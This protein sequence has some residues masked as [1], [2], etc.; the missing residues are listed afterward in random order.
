[1]LAV[2]YRHLIESG[3]FEFD[4]SGTYASKPI[5][6]QGEPQ[7]PA[8]PFVA[9]SKVE[10]RFGLPTTGRAA[11]IWCH[12]R[13]YLPRRYGFSENVLINRLFGERFWERDFLTRHAYGFQGLREE[14][15][16]DLIPIALPQVRGVVSDPWR[17]GLCL[18]QHRHRCPGVDPDRRPR[19]PPGVGHTRLAAALYSPIGDRYD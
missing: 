6:Q 18:L 14:D 1:M 15:D 13:R 5:E 12:L 8:I 17:W 10:G 4:A 9:R 3:R 16:Q 11:S 19:Y 2:E 7:P